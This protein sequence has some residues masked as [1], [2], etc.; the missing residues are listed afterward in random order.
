M[1]L[2]PPRRTSSGNL[3]AVVT[4]ASEAV[5][6]KLDS[7]DENMMPVADESL[8]IAD[9]VLATLPPTQLD[10]EAEAASVQIVVPPGS[11]VEISVPDEVPDEVP[12]EPPTKP[13]LDD[14]EDEN[15]GP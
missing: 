10:E 9:R 4:K 8:A 14:E 15:V 3:P 11:V 2:R 1:S 12:P 5:R 7:I 13:V 6:K